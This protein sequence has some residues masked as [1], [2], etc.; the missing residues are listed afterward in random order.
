MKF[1]YIWAY[2]KLTE[3]QAKHEFGMSSRTVV[4]WKMF[5]RDIC[6]EYLVTNPVRL[7]GPRVIVEI[8]ESQ[9]TR[10]KY[11]HGCLV[12]NQWVFGGIDRDTKIFSSC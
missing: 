8:D 1:V 3:K 2:K 9:F 4:D 6:A 11:N 10:R 7:S 5:L 12:M